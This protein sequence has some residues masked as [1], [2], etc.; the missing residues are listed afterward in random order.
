MDYKINDSY[1]SIG[2]ANES[3]IQGRILGINMIHTHR[4]TH[5]DTHRHTHIHTHT[6]TNTLSISPLFWE[7]LYR[8]RKM[9]CLVMKLY[10]QRVDFLILNDDPIKI[11]KIIVVIIV[12]TN[13]TYCKNVIIETSLH[14]WECV[15]QKLTASGTGRSHRACE[16]AP[17][18]GFRHLATFPA[19][20]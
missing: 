2:K 1:A 10:S 6:H 11:L 13:N 20:G 18:L 3:Y 16:A 4:H 19:R 14:R 12:T 9:H 8:T 5:I 7:G 17:F 15:L